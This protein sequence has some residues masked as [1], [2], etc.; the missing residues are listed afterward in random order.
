MAADNEA[1]RKFCSVNVEEEALLTSY[2]RPIVILRKKDGCNIPESVAPKIH[3][4]GFMLPYSPLHHLLMAEFNSPLV[5]TSGNI[6]DEPITYDDCVAIERLAKI[7]DCFLTHNREIHVRCDDSVVRVSSGKPCV[8]RRSRGYAPDPVTL[9][10]SMS[11]PILA[12]GAELK[13][14]FCLAKQN[15][16]FVSHHIGDLEN[17][18]TLR[19]FQE[20]I[21]HFKKLFDIEPEVVAYDLHP[22]YLSTKYAL[23]LPIPLKIGIQHHHAHVASCMADNGITG[24]VIGVAMDG[25][26]FGLD[27]KFWGCEFMIASL[28]TFQRVAHLQYLPMP[29]GSKAIREPWRMAA[30]YLQHAYGKDFVNLDLDF[31]KRLDFQIWKVLEK[32]QTPLT[33]SMGRCFDAVS[34]LLGIRDS[35]NYEGEAAIELEMIADEKEANRYEFD[36]SDDNTTIEITP[37]IVGIVNDI[38]AGILPSQISARFHNAVANL[39]VRMV[40]RIRDKNQLNRVA[41]SGGVFQNTLLLKK[42]I[43]LLK[44]EL[45]Q[46]FFHHR[47]PANDGGISLGQAVIA[48]ARIKAGLSI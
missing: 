41:L 39:I 46:V 21:E 24:D 28:E 4:L 31:S 35:I 26:G 37:V 43:A 3:S 8:I 32:L 12:C 20:G 45:F 47:V 42:T 19:S 9:P 27:G 25:L 38:H 22:E 34:S 23:E 29:G 1:I 30:T 48:D 16:A 13:N 10:F 7:A 36:I 5:M 40:L 11:L 33:S 44:D 18:E 14:T 15:Y 2:R 6:S 17:F